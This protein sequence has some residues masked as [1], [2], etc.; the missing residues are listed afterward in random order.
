MR[1]TLSNNLHRTS[2]TINAGRVSSKTV[3]RVRRAL[4]PSADCLCAQTSLGTRGKQVTEDGHTIVID[5]SQ[6]DSLV[7]YV[8]YI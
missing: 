1:I 8:D 5:E 7:V 2:C 6:G 3:R 4:C